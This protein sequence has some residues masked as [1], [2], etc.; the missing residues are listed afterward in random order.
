MLG[1]KILVAPVMDNGT[2]RMVKLP[3]G[4]WKDE[5]GNTY[6]GGRSYELDVPLSR[7]PMFYQISLKF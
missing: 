3:E 1:D 4:E 2:S 5:M 7:L 6:E